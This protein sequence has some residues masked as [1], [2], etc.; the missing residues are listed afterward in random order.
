REEFK[1]LTISKALASGQAKQYHEK[2]YSNARESYYTQK[3]SIDG[4]WY[5]RLAEQWNLRGEVQKEQFERLADGQDPETGKQLVKHVKSRKQTNK[6]GEKVETSEHR[7]GWD[8]TFSAPKSVSLAA[9]VGGDERI[10]E[11][12]RESVKAALGELEKY[13]EPRIGGNRPAQTTGN[14]VAAIFEHDAARPDRET[15]YA[16]P[17]LHSHAVIFNM[18]DMDGRIKPLQEKELFRSQKFATAVYRIH[19]AERLQN[20]GYE[21][22]VDQKGAPQIKGISKEYIDASSP[23]RREVEHQAAKLK[24]RL[25][26]DGIVVKD[27]AGIN[28]AAAL[29]D[30]RSKKYDPVE[31]RAR[32][33]EMDARFNHEARRVVEQAKE[34]GPVIRKPEEIERN[35]QTAVTF[36]R[37]NSMER[38]AVADWRNLRMDAYRR[39]LALTTYDAIE[40]EIASRQKAG[41]FV[42][43][44][45]DNKPKEMTTRQMLDLEKSNIRA[46]LDDKGK[47]RPIAQPE[48]A[49]K[50]IRKLEAIHGFN[51]NDG[52]REA[53][54]EILSGKDR[55]MGLQGGAGTGKTTVLRT[56]KEAAEESGYRLQGLAPTTR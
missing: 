8:A 33:L 39:G 19:L 56:I 37:D 41:E 20:L 23:R 30:R 42:K 47:E 50:T 14:F 55:I 45:R 44:E 16:A 21:V 53:I 10:N 17:Q 35:T 46:V 27:G 24:E 25:E 52:Q 49:E 6:Y 40:K 9:L 12:H 38:E 51:L 7:A 13:T 3:D 15:G 34:R 29:T 54:K 48:R 2:D 11:A 28:Q 5:G 1:M 26:K 32:H 36:A 18:T 31:M 43:I 4:Q 22:R